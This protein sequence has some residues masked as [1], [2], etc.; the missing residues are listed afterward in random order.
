MLTKSDIEQVFDSKADEIAQI[1]EVRHMSGQRY[2]ALEALTEE[3]SEDVVAGSQPKTEQKPETARETLGSCGRGS[4]RALLKSNGVFF[5][6][7]TVFVVEQ[8]S[9]PM[10]GVVLETPRNTE[11]ESKLFHFNPKTQTD[12]GS[13]SNSVAHC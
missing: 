10:Q 1:A 4:S 12:H 7:F 3:E 9:C 6:V 5:G 13:D 2:L 8:C 11:H